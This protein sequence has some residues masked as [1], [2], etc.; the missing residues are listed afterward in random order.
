MCFV[1]AKDFS[2]KSL[3]PVSRLRSRI[4]SCM[5]ATSESEESVDQRGAFGARVFR[6]TSLKGTVRLGESKQCTRRP[7]RSVAFS[8]STAELLL[9]SASSSPLARW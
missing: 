1:V 3:V 2:S 8:S 4:S 5:L 6:L 9:W 7:P